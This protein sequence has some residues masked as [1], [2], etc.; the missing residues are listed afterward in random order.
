MI[1]SQATVCG[2]I[3]RSA[4][5]RNSKDGKPFMK[6]TM[7]VGFEDNGTNRNIEVHVYRDGTDERFMA[8]FQA[9]TRVC[10]KGMLNFYKADESLVF[11]IRAQEISFE[12]V[13]EDS[14]TGTLDFMGIMGKSIYQKSDRK[15]HPYI[16]FAAYSMDRKGEEYSFTW[17]NFMQFN[18]EKE[19]WMQPG[20]GVEI[21]GDIEVS[22]YQGKSGVCCRITSVTEWDK[23]YK[24]EN[25]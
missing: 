25:R 24:H 12:P 21:H 4:E 13:G 19:P 3:S 16:S 22:V 15:G 1:K 5:M 8:D 17:I 6:F 10:V 11:N 23:H 9:G 2:T 7:N 20:C 18:R 14:I